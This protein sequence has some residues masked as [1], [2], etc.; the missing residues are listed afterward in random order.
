MVVSSV[1][2]KTVAD[3]PFRHLVVVVV[4]ADDEARSHRPDGDNEDQAQRY[5]AIHR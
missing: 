3:K 1:V 4:V 2:W 5:P